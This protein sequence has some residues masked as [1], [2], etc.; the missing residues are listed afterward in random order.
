MAKQLVR[1]LLEGDGTVPKFILDGG[2]YPI[3]E[4]M[5]GITVDEDIRYV[6]STVVRMDRQDVIDWLNTLGIGEGY[7]AEAMADSLIAK[8]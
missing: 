4:E 1:Y 5:I 3:N 7:S 2:Y 8:L 6:P